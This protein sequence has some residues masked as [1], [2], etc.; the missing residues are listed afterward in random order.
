MSFLL[1]VLPFYLMQWICRFY[2]AQSSL[3]KLLKWIA[4]V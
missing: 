4:S 2:P 1:N 3:S